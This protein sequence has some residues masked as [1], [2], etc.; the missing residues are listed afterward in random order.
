MG[1][2]PLSAAIMAAGSIGAAA[3]S[4]PKGI[5]APTQRSYLGEMQDALRSQGGIQKELL[6]LDGQY[7]P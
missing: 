4:K 5:K 3:I 7:T 6:D 2:D 1:A